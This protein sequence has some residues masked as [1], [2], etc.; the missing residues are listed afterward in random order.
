MIY[1][2]IQGHEK[3]NDVQTAVQIF[4]PNEKY[5]P[6][7]QVMEEGTTVKSVLTEDAA[8]AYLYENGEL[9][10]S[11]EYKI[12]DS[13]NNKSAKYAIK[14]AVY[15]ML[16]NETGI[17]VPWGMMTGIRPAKRINTYMDEGMTAD[18]SAEKLIKLYEM[19]S[20]K[21]ELAKTVALAER[22][23]L[24][25]ADSNGIS[26]YIGIPFCPTR[27]LYCSFT[28]YPLDKYSSKVDGYIDALMKELKFLG[29]KA[30]GKRLDSIYIGGGTPTSLTAEQLNRLMVGVGD[31]F[32]LNNLLEYTVEAGRPDTITPDK[33]K[34]IKVNGADRISINPQTMNDKTLKLIGRNHSVDDIKRVYYEARE[35]GHNNINMDLILGLPEEGEIEVT[36]TM[37]EIEKL[38]PENLTVHTLAIKRASKLRETLE[39]YDLAKAMLMEKL[40]GISSEGAK[41]M[42]LSPYYMYKQ[43]NM[44]GSFE[45]VGY[46][47]K[48]CESV[49]NIVI[50]EETQS[51][52]AAGAGAST[53]LYDSASGRIERIFNV[54]NVDEYI[55]RIDEMIGRK[56]KGM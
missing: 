15:Y 35:A 54:K 8:W 27:C 19:T 4:M 51:I 55:S 11:Y 37:E 25:K 42:G 23:I 47:K 26:L 44:L 21:A 5:K 7:E 38:A 22:E 18:E 3:M 41:G 39:D 46:A 24:K 34:V 33:L 9:K 10:C 1:I 56:Q 17:Y 48:G 20:S 16:K 6:T 53:K 28:S 13:N 49:Y 40:I 52:Y 30:K 36:H 32:D 2:Y 43:K 45:N 29:E 12:G 50:M 31:I 14:A